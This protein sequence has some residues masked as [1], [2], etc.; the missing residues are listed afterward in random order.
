[1][2]ILCLPVICS[3]LPNRK[4]LTGHTFSSLTVRN[5]WVLPKP[6]TFRE[7]CHWGL[8]DLIPSNSRFSQ[9]DTNQGIQM[10]L[11]AHSRCRINILANCTSSRKPSPAHLLIM[12]WP[13]LSSMTL[14]IWIP[15]QLML[16]HGSFHFI[17]GAWEASVQWARTMCQTPS[18][19]WGYKS[20]QA[21]PWLCGVDI[22][23]L[24]GFPSFICLMSSSFK[25]QR[26][27]STTLD[28]SPKHSMPPPLAQTKFILLSSCSSGLLPAYNILSCSIVS[29]SWCPPSS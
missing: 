26:S 29:S 15:E 5:S 19:Y 9:E 24:D 20:E 6:C 23:K 8:S 3:C 12:I 1:M 28:D 21:K 25:N 13:L 11:C 22:L 10:P 7:G 14:A 2:S 4:M 18:R 27:S 16:N 17:H